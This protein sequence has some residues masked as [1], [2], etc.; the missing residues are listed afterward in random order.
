VWASIDA[1]RILVEKPEGR[2]HFEDRRVY[3]RIILKWILEMW[4]GVH[5]LDQSG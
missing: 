3:G 4:V 1:Y 5:G 2:N